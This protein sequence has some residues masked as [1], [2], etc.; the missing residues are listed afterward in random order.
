M[1]LWT[2]NPPLLLNHLRHCEH[3]VAPHCSYTGFCL[4]VTHLC[5]FLSLSFLKHLE[6]SSSTSY[7]ALQLTFDDVA[8]SYHSC[9][10]TFTSPFVPSLPQLLPDTPQEPPLCCHPSHFI[11]TCTLDLCNIPPLHPFSTT[12]SLSLERSH[13]TPNH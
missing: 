3:W 4:S 1:H 7:R 12:G 11:H 9:S 5:L 6:L 8:S 13:T 10:P 2:A